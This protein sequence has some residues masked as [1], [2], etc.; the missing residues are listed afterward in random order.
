MADS[1]LNSIV[2][3]IDRRS[4]GS[5]AGA[6]GEPEQSV[7]NGTESAVAAVL[8]G[9]C[10]KADDHGMLRR[11]LDM[12]PGNLGD[13]TGSQIASNISNQSLPLMSTGKQ[14]LSSLF[15]TSEG[16]VANELSSDSGLR[17][18]KLSALLASVAPLVV[19]FLGKRV[20]EQGMT[21]SGLANLLDRESPAIRRALPASL[22]ELFWPRET[23]AASPVVAQSVERERSSTNWLPLIAVAVLVPALFWMFHHARRPAN[24]AERTIPPAVS[25]RTGS[26]N[27][28]VTPEP[29][30]PA[31]RPVTKD[32][33]LW[34]DTSSAR[35]RPDSRRRLNDI[36]ATL[37]ANPNTHA[38][39][40][41]YTDS[42]GTTEKNAMLSENRA[43]AVAA[44][45]AHK[46]IAADRLSTEG[47]GE[48]NPA[49]DNATAAGRAQN[50]RVV[51]TVTQM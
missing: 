6:L 11:F 5:I 34:F 36:A 26:A 23:V 18:G 13:I 37:A 38:K 7:A 30:A 31:S 4:M 9:L 20:R 47:Y 8:A 51:V 41:G 15:G 32:I 46:G 17:P 2:S 42:M 50:R 44:E 45:L 19:G 49:A 33:V 3:L 27:R 1:L 43:K 48:Q 21:M 16:M 12:V 35:L 29:V 25:E 24:V 39:V 10:S 28:V 14:I 40:S 22:H